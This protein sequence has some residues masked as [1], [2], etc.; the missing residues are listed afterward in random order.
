MKLIKNYN[1]HSFLEVSSQ[2]YVYIFEK[3]K[4]DIGMYYNLTRILQT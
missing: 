2:Y 1:L 4:K 3:L